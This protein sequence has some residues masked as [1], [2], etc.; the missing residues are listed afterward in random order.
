MKVTILTVL[1]AVLVGGCET[2]R[3]E[4]SR[5]FT[6]PAQNRPPPLHFS[7]P[8]PFN[9]DVTSD[10]PGAMIEVNDDARCRAPCVIIVEGQGDRT[11]P[12]VQPYALTKIQAIPTEEGGAVQTKWLSPGQKIPERIFFNMRLMRPTPEIDINVNE[13]L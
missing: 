6:Q 10:P 5:Q 1:T 4:P 9:V 3:L 13:G 7:Y 2:P 12:R 11:V 8:R